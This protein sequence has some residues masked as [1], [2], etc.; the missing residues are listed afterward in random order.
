M[1]T[2]LRKAISVLL[3]LALLL[4]VAAMA[5]QEVP[6]MEDVSPADWF[7]SYVTRSFHFGLT[8]GTGGDGF[9][10]EP[11]RNVTRAEFVTM[12]GRLH[13]YFNEPINAPDAPSFYYH[14]LNLAVAYGI[15]H[16]D[17]YGDLMPH[18][19]ITRE[20]MAVIVYRYVEAFG[21]CRHFA[22]QAH[23]AVPRDY[24]DISTWARHEVVQMMYRYWLMQGTGP[25]WARM[26]NP[27]ANSSRA[28]ALTTLVRLGNV[29]YHAAR[30]VLTISVEEASLPQGERFRVHVEL[31]NYSGED[32][33]IAYDHLFFSSIPSW[34]G[35]RCECCGHFVADAP[36]P[37]RI[38][39]LEADGIKQNVL[40]S[41]NIL[42][43]G[44]YELRFSA[45]F[46]L[47]FER[48]TS[49]GFP[50]TPIFLW[51]DRIEVWSNSV[52]ITVR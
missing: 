22:P 52:I 8:T 16:G 38:S 17:G 26:F 19:L 28:E 40:H 34:H 9:R 23:G 14:Y 24:Q 44:T 45:R 2:N 49:P 43:P 11:Y 18:V 50:D 47:Q 31:K 1:Q 13:E 27:Q 46:W 3:V 4:P 35:H 42:E 32:V 7:Y 25:D 33:E 20:Q 21:L 30:F 37:P 5:V 41:G 12:L 29:L 48:Y 51:D 36:P 39:L 15:V 10:F 6:D